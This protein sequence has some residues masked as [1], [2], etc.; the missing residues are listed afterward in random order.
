M[1]RPHSR[2][3]R[4]GGSVVQRDCGSEGLKSLCKVVGHTGVEQ[5]RHRGA[6]DIVVD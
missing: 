3:P 4:Y 5:G 2:W 6:E 1:V